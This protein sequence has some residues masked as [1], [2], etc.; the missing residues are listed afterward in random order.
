MAHGHMVDITTS[1]IV[2]QDDLENL[3]FFESLELLDDD[4]L[5]KLFLEKS[6]FQDS[7]PSD[8]PAEEQTESVDGPS[9]FFSR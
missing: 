8:Q 1:K 4:D 5:E 9:R 2:D 3:D 7:V 6:L